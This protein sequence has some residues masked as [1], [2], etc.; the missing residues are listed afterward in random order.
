METVL[1]NCDA[2]KEV[3]D[4]NDSH[5]DSKDRTGSVSLPSKGKQHKYGTYLILF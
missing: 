3:I 1:E 2:L 4:H 5:L